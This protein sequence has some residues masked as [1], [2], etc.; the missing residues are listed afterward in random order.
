MLTS[1]YKMIIT[2]APV[3][4]YDICNYGIFLDSGCDVLAFVMAFVMYIRFVR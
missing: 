2:S 3:P 4:K 1:L